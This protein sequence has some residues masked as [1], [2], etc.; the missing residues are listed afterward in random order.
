MPS[1]IGHSL[2]G[3][4]VGAAFLLRSTPGSLAGIMAEVRARLGLII[5]CVLLANLPDVDLIPGLLTGDLNE[6]HRGYTHS[7]GWILL[8]G[9]GIWLLSRPFRPPARDLFSWWVITVVLL[10]HPVVDLFCEDRGEPVGILFWW[11]FSRRYIQGPVDV[12][13]AMEKSSVAAVLTFDNV[14]PAIREA[15]V[16]TVF[17]AFVIAWKIRPR[18]RV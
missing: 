7:V 8:V 15:L 11:P 6:F 10:A 14:G 1:P 16:G 17:L 12:F 2:I 9:A 5:G 3:A 18:G 4:A 13:P